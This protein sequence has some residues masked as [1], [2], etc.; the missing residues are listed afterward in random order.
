MENFILLLNFFGGI[1]IVFA[2]GGLIGHLLKLD[3]YFE[4]KLHSHNEDFQCD[5]NNDD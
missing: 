5:C 1:I 4:E 3:K 2:V